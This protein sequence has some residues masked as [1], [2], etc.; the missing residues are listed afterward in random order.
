VVKK[1]KRKEKVFPKITKQ[2]TEV[3]RGRE[4]S[5]AHGLVVWLPADGLWRC[6]WILRALTNRWI[7]PLM[8]S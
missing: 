8:G 4:K 5:Q 7:S 2:M 3:K 1:G 6:N